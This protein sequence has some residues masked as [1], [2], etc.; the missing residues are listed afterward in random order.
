M[1]HVD[2]SDS[3]NMPKELFLSFCIVLL[4]GDCGVARWGVEH[5]SLALLVVLVVKQMRRKTGRKMEILHLMSQQSSRTF[6]L[7]RVK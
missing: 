7:F 1:V 3:P 2:S 6:F 4:R 5:G